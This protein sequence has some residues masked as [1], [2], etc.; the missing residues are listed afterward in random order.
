VNLVG[1]IVRIYHDARSPEGQICYNTARKRI[2]D[3]VF[4]LRDFLNLND[5]P[6]DTEFST[7]K[8]SP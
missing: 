7:V 1:F 2:H 6:D 4:K 5:N 3:S 8:Q